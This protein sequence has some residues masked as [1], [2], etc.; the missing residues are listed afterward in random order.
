[1]I[2]FI[3]ITSAVN[4]PDLQHLI[5]TPSV[6]AALISSKIY[7]DGRMGLECFPR[8]ICPH[9]SRYYLCS[10]ITCDTCEWLNS[11]STFNTISPLPHIPMTYSCINWVGRTCI[12][13][14]FLIYPFPS[15]HFLGKWSRKSICRWAWKSREII[16]IIEMQRWRRHPPPSSTETV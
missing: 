4:C 2:N 7:S 15:L 11:V 9:T 5:N 12:S 1:M 10:S 16:E 3:Y 14:P 13:R 6:R 8:F